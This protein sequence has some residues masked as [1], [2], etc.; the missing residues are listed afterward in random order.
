MVVLREPAVERDAAGA[1]DRG[2]GA[3]SLFGRIE[4]LSFSAFFKAS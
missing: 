2:G 3:S 4:A 1:G